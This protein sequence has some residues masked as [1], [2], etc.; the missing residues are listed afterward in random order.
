MKQEGWSIVRP[1]NT[2]SSASNAEVR[3]DTNSAAL[4]ARL[5]YSAL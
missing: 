4:E 2:S 3:V 1:E 5:P